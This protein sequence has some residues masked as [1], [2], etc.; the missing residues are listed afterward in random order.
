MFSLQT[1]GG[2]LSMEETFGLLW[3]T[4]VKP[5]ALA[6]HLP[7]YKNLA[8]IGTENAQAPKSECFKKQAS[9]FTT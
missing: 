5:R 3:T 2:N 8:L 6:N 1:E 7:D 9:T 4:F